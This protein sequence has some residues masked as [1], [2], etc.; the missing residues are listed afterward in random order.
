[1]SSNMIRNGFIFAGLTN[2]FGV[3]LFSKAFT[4]QVMMGIQP[5]IMGCFGLISIMLWGLGYIAVSKSYAQVRWLIAVFAIEKL[6]YVIAWL[7]FVTTR[8]LSEVYAQDI[9]AGIFYAIYGL[10][11]FVFMLFFVYVLVKTPSPSH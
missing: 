9:F 11:D 5:G 10:N 6:A 4:N 1:M 2:I 3:L 8:S 7:S